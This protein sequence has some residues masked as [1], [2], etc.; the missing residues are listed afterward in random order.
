SPIAHFARVR[1]PMLIIHSEGDLR[2]NVEQ[3]EQVFV[4]LKQRGIPAR[5]VR[6]PR[7]TSHGM[8]RNG[9]PDLRIHRLNEIVR[10]WA[11]HLRPK[12]TT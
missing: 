9:P 4:A 12:P 10:W 2:C 1:T 7:N 11:S 3:S 8:S 5:F 6:Y